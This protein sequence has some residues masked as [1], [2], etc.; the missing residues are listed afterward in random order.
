MIAQRGAFVFGAEQAS[1]LKYRH[2]EL[3]EILKAFME[4][5]RHH[6]EAV[7]GVFVE[8]RLRRVGDTFG[9]ADVGPRMIYHRSA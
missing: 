1:L 8:P 7:G 4:I 9:Y 6:I 5:G 2:H 3:Y